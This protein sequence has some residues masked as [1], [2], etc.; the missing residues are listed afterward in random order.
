MPPRRKL[1]LTGSDA[2]SKGS[3]IQVTFDTNNTVTL[4]INVCICRAKR[5]RLV[6]GAPISTEELH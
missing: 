2:N 1:V 6:L 3:A 4:N 5:E